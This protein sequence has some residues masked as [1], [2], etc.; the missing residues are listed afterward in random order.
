M[1]DDVQ[2]GGRVDDP[3][4]R[5]I[6]T[7]V[8][9][10]GQAG[11]LMSWHLQRAGRSHVVL[12]RRETLGGGWQDRWDAFRLVGPN[13]TT[14]LPGYPYDGSDPDAFMT[15]DEVAAR[16][17]AYADVISAPIHRAT[18]VLRLSTAGAGSRRF[19]IETSHG[20]IDADDVIVATGAFHVP[21]IPAAAA[22]ISPRL[23]QL[24]AHHYRNDTDLPQGGVLIVGSGQTGVQLAD[25]LRS[26]GREVVL[27]VGHCGRAPRR[28]RGHD[29][30]WWFRRL[31]THGPELGLPLPSVDRLADPR[32][33]F[34]CNPHLSGHAG[35]HDTNLRQMARDG[36]RLAGRFESAAGERARFSAD[37][38][39]NLRFADEFFDARF[40]DLIDT[41]AERA[42]MSVPDDDR[43]WPHF[44][45]P[46]LTELSLDGSGI[47]TVLWTTGYAPDYG[48]LDLPIFD[49]AGLPR[50]RRGISEVPG[51]SFI[52]LL[53]QH[54]NASANLLGVFADA[55]Y[56]VSR[57]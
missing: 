37:L 10:A 49:E 23:R 27:S 45:P 9:G 21:K 41:F 25:E 17:R 32:L 8:I 51:L 12:D 50:H 15:R 42:G 33:R 43:Q 24:H 7:V 34:A 56:L 4:P 2:I 5:S 38:G 52:G 3:W 55:E 53:W 13:W 39:E 35:G 31:V 44:E 19:H 18:E 54:T 22:G 11:L 57:W 48:W 30:F 29:F 28:Y 36:L 40:R 26:A 20:P 6:D 46:E 16:M 47:G 1:M 14:D